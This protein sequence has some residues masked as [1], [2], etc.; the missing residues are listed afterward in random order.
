MRIQIVTIQTLFELKSAG[1]TSPC[2][3]D[4]TIFRY[5]VKKQ[6]RPDVSIRASLQ[7]K[8]YDVCY[9]TT[10]HSPVKKHKRPRVKAG[11]SMQGLFMKRNYYRIRLYCNNIRFIVKQKRPRCGLGR[12][13]CYSYNQTEFN[14]DV[15]ILPLIIL[16]SRVK[17]RNAPTET[18]NI[19]AFLIQNISS[20]L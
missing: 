4:Y 8:L 7:G 17:N 18:L 10:F 1:I 19:G 6:R 2:V 13:C 12:V 3:Y 14:Y 16:L 9:C 5:Y 15:I 11:A 20:V